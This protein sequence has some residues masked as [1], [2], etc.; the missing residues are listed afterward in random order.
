MFEKVVI[1]PKKTLKQLYAMQDKYAS[2]KIPWKHL[3]FYHEYKLAKKRQRLALPKDLIESEFQRRQT[4]VVVDEFFRDGKPMLMMPHLGQMVDYW[5]FYFVTDGRI[6]SDH[7]KKTRIFK[8]ERGGINYVTWATIL[9]RSEGKDWLPVDEAKAY[10][11]ICGITEACN[12]VLSEIRRKLQGLQIKG[13]CKRNQF[14]NLNN[15]PEF[16]PFQQNRTYDHKRFVWRYQPRKIGGNGGRYP[17]G[18]PTRLE[19]NSIH[20]MTM[21]LHEWLPNFRAKRG[22]MKKV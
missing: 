17:P 19:K 9:K 10:P 20:K 7:N 15:H 2:E 18:R 22:R 11:L 5:I 6:R 21:E 1:L 8:F 14:Q 13:D 3:A 12:D 4:A 16:V